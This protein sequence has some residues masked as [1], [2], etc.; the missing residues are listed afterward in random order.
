MLRASL[1]RFS[2]GVV[3][4]EMVGSAKRDATAFAVFWDGEVL[5]SR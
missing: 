1:Q 4:L 2:V 3:T 5:R